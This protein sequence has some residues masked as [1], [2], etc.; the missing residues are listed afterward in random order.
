MEECNGKV[1]PSEEEDLHDLLEWSGFI[2]T[3]IQLTEKMS[4]Q[5]LWN[6][7]DVVR[8]MGCYDTLHTLSN[9]VAKETI[10][11]DFSKANQ[12]RRKIFGNIYE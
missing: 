9:Q 12:A 8:M 3:Y 2:L 10:L 4:G 11:Q 7:Y 1:L 6:D 5:K